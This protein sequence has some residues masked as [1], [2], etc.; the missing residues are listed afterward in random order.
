[1]L[2]N[3]RL[4][5]AHLV[6]RHDR[7][8]RPPTLS[9]A[10]PEAAPKSL[11]SSSCGSS[12]GSDLAALIDE[13][14]AILKTLSLE[15]PR[16]SEDIYGMDMSIMWGSDDLEWCNGGLAGCTGREGEV[17]ARGGA[18]DKLLLNVCPCAAS[19]EVQHICQRFDPASADL[20]PTPTHVS[21]TI[22]SSTILDIDAFLCPL[23]RAPVLALL[24]FI[25]DTR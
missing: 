23:S 7:R 16:G 14:H 3:C 18:V 6:R 17:Q 15:D 21:S 8:L 10:L 9:V 1:M 22:V 4:S 11:P 24:F 20:L 12:L 2:L 19:S 13:L 25:L 5:L